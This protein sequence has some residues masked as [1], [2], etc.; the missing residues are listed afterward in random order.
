M[1]RRL[2]RL[3]TS[4]RQPRLDEQA[5]ALGSPTAFEL[6]AW[7]SALRAPSVTRSDRR[8]PG[9]YANAAD[10]IYLTKA[11]KQLLR[12]DGSRAFT[13]SLGGCS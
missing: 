9:L 1:E 4:A 11:E 12:G 6:V 3:C 13:I 5:D 10:R 7:S 2:R 8:L